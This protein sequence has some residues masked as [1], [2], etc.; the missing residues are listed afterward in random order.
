MPNHTFSALL[1]GLSSF[2]D[3][4]Q[5]DAAEQHANSRSIAAVAEGKQNES[6]RDFL[7][8]T[9]QKESRSLLVLPGAAEEAVGTGE[10]RHVWCLKLQKGLR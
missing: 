2:H 5:T 9:Y 6:S 7:C 8:T 3:A 10:P 1:D 4:F